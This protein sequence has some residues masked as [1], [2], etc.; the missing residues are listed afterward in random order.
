MFAMSE[1]SAHI[2][3][4]I[5]CSVI[6]RRHRL[7]Y[8][9]TFEDMVPPVERIE[10]VGR[11]GFCLIASSSQQASYFSS[12]WIFFIFFLPIPAL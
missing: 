4:N 11:P 10:T 6:R 5:L 8:S 1:S 12:I 2:L 9:R 3:R 7:S